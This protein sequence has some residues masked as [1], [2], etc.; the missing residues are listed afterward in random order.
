MIAD[1]NITAERTIPIYAHSTEVLGT[2]SWGIHS[3]YVNMYINNY[4]Q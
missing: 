4:L 3:K 2:R 1:W